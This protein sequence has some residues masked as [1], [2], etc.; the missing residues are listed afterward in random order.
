MFILLWK[1]WQTLFSAY[2]SHFLPLPSLLMSWPRVQDESLFS[3]DRRPLWLR[4]YFNYLALSQESCSHLWWLVW[5]HPCDPVLENGK[6]WESC[7][8]HLGNIFPPDFKRDT[9]EDKA[10][11]P[12]WDL[13]D[14]NWPQDRR[15]SHPWWTCAE[16]PLCLLLDFL[17]VKSQ[18][19]YISSSSWAGF[20]RISPQWGPRR[21]YQQPVLK[22][23][24][25][26]NMPWKLEIELF[27]RHLKAYLL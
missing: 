25:M 17:E 22:D 4:I 12:A 1:F 24:W 27:L 21:D 23:D 9:Q 2:N 5:E 16:A 3:L 19:P 13:S 18:C 26:V 8:G 14:E 6:N 10:F 11:L 15:S 7:W 20:L